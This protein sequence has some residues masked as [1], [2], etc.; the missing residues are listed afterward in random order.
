MNKNGEINTEHRSQE[1]CIFLQQINK[2]ANKPLQ[3]LKTVV[4][5]RNDRITSE[6]SI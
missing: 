3:A 2:Q 6:F 5:K 1:V 4:S